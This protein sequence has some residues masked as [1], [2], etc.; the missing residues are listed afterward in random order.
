MKIVKTT[1][2][3][4]NVCFSYG[5]TECSAAGTLTLPFDTQGGHVGGPSSWAH[6]KLVDVPDLGYF[7]ADDKGEICF[8][9]AAIMVGYYGDEA[10]T[11]ETIDKDGQ[12]VLH[13]FPLVKT[14]HFWPK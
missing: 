4:E 5:Q 1:S 11:R 6:V 9:G 2:A 10:L 13:S 12:D 8:R 14:I 7:A 3:K